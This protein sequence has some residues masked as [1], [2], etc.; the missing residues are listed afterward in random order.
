MV[1]TGKLALFGVY[2]STVSTKLLQTAYRG[3]TSLMLQD[4]TGWAIGDEIVIAP[5][6]TNSNEY[7]RV[8]ITGIIDNIVTFTPALNYTHYGSSSITISNSV[9]E[10]DTRASV[11]HITRNIKFI[12]GPDNGWG[13]T[14]VNYQI[15]EG[16]KARTGELMLS[17]VEF[18][19]GGQYDTEA[20]TLNLQNYDERT[21]PT[22]VVQY[23]SFSYC[24]SFC[25]KAEG[26]YNANITKNVF[27]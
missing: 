23:S 12:S 13:Y 14:I 2:P 19:Q 11:G 4:V 20:A 18:G 10:L 26:H 25:L 6:F 8:Q 5:S 15:W 27:Y 3:N 24:R 9:G 17:G 21:A 16:A 1:V 22:T 7:E